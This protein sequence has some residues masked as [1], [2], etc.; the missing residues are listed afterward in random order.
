MTEEI[1]AGRTIA[2]VWLDIDGITTPGGDPAVEAER[3]KAALYPLYV[4][5]AGLSIRAKVIE[6]RA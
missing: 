5:L 6:A 4:P 1:D 3:V 2:S